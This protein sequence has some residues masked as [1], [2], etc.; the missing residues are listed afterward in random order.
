MSRL[1]VETPDLFAAA[2][3]RDSQ[4]PADRRYL[5]PNNLPTALTHLS[6]EEFRVLADAVYQERDRR[7]AALRGSRG[8]NKVSKSSL[9][10]KPHEHKTP[11]TISQ[12]L[13]KSRIN[14]IRAVIKAGVKPRTAARQFGISL[15]ALQEAMRKELIDNSKSATPDQ[16][17]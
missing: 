16:C 10:S 6:D 7:T 13:T 9:R 5:L 12:P 11:M 4:A 15:S 8:Q 3:A 2:T 17:G 14:A 1:T